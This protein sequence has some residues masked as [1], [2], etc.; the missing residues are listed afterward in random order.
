MLRERIGQVASFAL[1][2]CQHMR[3]S[4][5]CF[6]Q[7]GR[8][9]KGKNRIDEPMRVA[10][11]NITFSAKTA[12]LVGIVW[13]YVHF[14]DQLYV[15]DSARESG[16]GSREEDYG[17]TLREFAL[18]PGKSRLVPLIRGLPPRHQSE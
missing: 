16:I 9:A 15:G 10:D 13:N 6:P 14:L 5:L 12:N 18:I 7:S 1:E 8:D 4:K 11:A 2:I 17:R 3:H